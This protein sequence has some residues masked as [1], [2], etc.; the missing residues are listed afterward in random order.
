MPRPAAN[1]LGMWLDWALILFYLSSFCFHFNA[2]V[3]FLSDN[4][5]MAIILC[6]KSACLLMLL[7]LSY[8][9]E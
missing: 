3:K 8:T 4:L 7:P 6:H 9:G 2:T 1:L 5:N